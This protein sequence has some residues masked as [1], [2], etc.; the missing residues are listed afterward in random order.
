VAK[1]LHDFGYDKAGIRAWLHE[2]M[3]IPAGITESYARHVGRTGFSFDSTVTDPALRKIYVSSDDP[4]RLVPMNMDPDWIS[5]V[6]GGNPSRNQSRA[7]IGNLT[8]GP[9]ATKV[10]DLPAE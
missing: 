3:W 5:I 7:Y 2:N 6:I 4:E 8:A 9:P 10:I 1:A